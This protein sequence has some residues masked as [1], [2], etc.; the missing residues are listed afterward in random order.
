MGQ[1]PSI[2]IQDVAKAAGVSVSTV[3]RVLNDKDDVAEATYEKVQHTIAEMGYTSNLAAKSLR[4]HRTNTIGVVALDLNDPFAIQ[5]LLGINRAIR[6]LGYDLILYASGERKKSTYAAWEQRHVSQINGSVADGVI[7]VT[8]AAVTFPT[9]FPLV[10]IDPHSGDT[11][12][13]AVI[14]TN[15]EG[16]QGVMEYLIGL[17]HQRIGFIAGREHLKSAQQRLRGYRESLQKAK[18]ALY[19]ELIRQGDYRRETGYRC[20]KELLDLPNPPTAIFAANDESAIGTIEAA[21]DAGL[22]IPDDLS[23]VGF[24][25][26][27][28]TTDITPALTTVEQPMNEMGYAATEI[29]I[30]LMEGKSLNDRAHIMPTKLIIRDSCRAIT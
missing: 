6:E 28:G 13:P 14:A 18:I 5:V 27:P 8:P 9:T 22:R 21:R 4:S 11:D 19:P 2:T 17:G 3:S 29:L 10:A 1:K 7:I 25:N 20:A 26:M 12:Y 30:N 23:V 15:R 24:D 16:A